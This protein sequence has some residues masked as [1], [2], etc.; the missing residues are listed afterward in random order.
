MQRAQTPRPHLKAAFSF[1]SAPSPISSFSLMLTELW[2]SSG[3]K[4]SRQRPSRW[5]RKLEK[6]RSPSPMCIYSLSI[7]NVTLTHLTSQEGILAVPRMFPANLARMLS[8]H[9]DARPI[10]ISY[11]LGGGCLTRDDPVLA[12]GSLFATNFPPV[13]P[14]SY[15][16]AVP[17]FPDLFRRSHGLGQYRQIRCS[18]G[19]GSLL[20]CHGSI[21][22]TESPN[23]RAVIKMLSI[24]W[25]QT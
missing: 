9:F 8:L 23:C 12:F 6:T 15:F 16:N 1:S 24:P 25:T 14:L 11:F 7:H 4:P 19:T 10:Q 20:C 17:T 21:P 2:L 13:Q 22:F 18:T 3:S 5:L